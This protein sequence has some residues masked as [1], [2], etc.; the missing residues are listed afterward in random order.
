MPPVKKKALLRNPKRIPHPSKDV[1][2]KPGKKNHQGEGGGRPSKKT[3]LDFG[4]IETF[5]GFGLIDEQICKAL[6]ISVPTLE[7]W[8]K[9]EKFLEAIKKG[10]EIADNRVV[11]SLYDR[12]TGYS[13]R[14]DDIRVVDGQIVIT[15]TVKHYPPDP[16]SM[17][18][19]LKNRK[20]A[21]W[22]D[23]QEVEHDIAG[24]LAD[25]MRIHLAE[26]KR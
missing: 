10:K 17:I 16:T 1:P 26:K 14:E 2:K 18:F 19:W 7:N 15:E 11:R 23:R 6:D 5:Y 3:T 12:A 24:N 22:R 4:M 13:H 9:D 8:K 21:E 25:L 20:R